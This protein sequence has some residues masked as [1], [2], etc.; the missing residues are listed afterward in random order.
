MITVLTYVHYTIKT[1]HFVNYYLHIDVQRTDFIIKPD[2]S[3]SLI[4]CAAIHCSL[5]GLIEKGNE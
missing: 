4:L 5:R 3:D 2:A 1:T